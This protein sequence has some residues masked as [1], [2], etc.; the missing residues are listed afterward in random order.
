M[1]PLRYKPIVSKSTILM[2]EPDLKG[3]PSKKSRAKDF[4]STSFI[5]ANPQKMHRRLLLI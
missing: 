4:N 1:G 3:K 5:R 2:F